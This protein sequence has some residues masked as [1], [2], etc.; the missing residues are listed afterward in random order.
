MDCT[1]HGC[2]L[3]TVSSPVV[4]VKGTG[5][6]KTMMTTASLKPVA[7]QILRHLANAQAKGRV[8]RLDELASDIGV[9]REDVRHAVTCL[10]AEGHVDA[11]RLKLTLSGFAVA[12]SMRECKLRAARPR[13]EQHHVQHQMTA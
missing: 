13:M 4:L 8:V 7:A 1:L 5:R 12:C 11:Q 6:Q 3:H 9:R 2:D 10:H